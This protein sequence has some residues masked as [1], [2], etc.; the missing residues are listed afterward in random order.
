MKKILYNNKEY[1]EYEY[2]YEEDFEKDIV[3]YA[4]EIFG[5]KTIYIDVK[6]LLKA[7]HSKGTISDGYLLDYTNENRP[8]LYLIENE[9]ISHPVKDHIAKQIMNFSINYKYNLLEIK[10]III[11][12]LA[13][14]N[15]DIDII[16][17]NANYRNADDMLTSIISKEPLG[18][19]IPMDKITEELK[20]IKTLFRFDIE[21]LEFKKFYNNNDFIYFYDKFNE[22]IQENHNEYLEQN[23]IIVPAEE[24]GFKEEFINNNRW[25]SVAIKINMKDKLKYTAVYQKN[26]ISYNPL[27]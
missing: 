27:C 9:T 20:E 5:S 18:V 6:K 11:S 26:Y 17:K 25:Y 12:K 4:K 16:A 23:T 19:I 22:E 15:I 10:D 21:L 8:K 1:T 24:E 3:S 7:K 13:E 14:N 2:I